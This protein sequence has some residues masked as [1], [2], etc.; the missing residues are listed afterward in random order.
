[1]G[2]THA[3]AGSNQATSLDRGDLNNAPRTHVSMWPPPDDRLDLTQLVALLR[4]NSRALLAWALVVIG[5]V[6]GFTL[7]AP[8]D[9]QA[10]GRLYLGELDAENAPSSAHRAEL[11][12]SGGEPGDLGSE[13]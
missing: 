10:R 13:L 5:L 7:L 3:R 11:D 9:F 12:L 8:M 1:M 6:S 2:P 4:A